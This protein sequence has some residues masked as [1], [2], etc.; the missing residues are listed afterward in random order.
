[1]MKSW[2][3]LSLWT[4][5]KFLIRLAMA[6]NLLVK[7]NINK[8]MAENNNAGVDSSSSMDGHLQSLKFHN[9]YA[10]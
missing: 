6:K 8:V 7:A 2:S 3:G 5:C 9:L 4:L 1:M 10:I